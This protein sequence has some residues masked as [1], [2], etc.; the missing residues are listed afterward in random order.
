MEIE[1]RKLNDFCCVECGYIEEYDETHSEYSENECSKLKKKTK[2]LTKFEKKLLKPHVSKLELKINKHQKKVEKKIEQKQSSIYQGIFMIK[3][4]DEFFKKQ[5]LLTTPDL[6]KYAKKVHITYDKKGNEVILD[7]EICKY[8]SWRCELPESHIQHAGCNGCKYI[9]NK[10][11]IFI[12]EDGELQHKLKK[13]K[14]IIDG[15][16]TIDENGNIYFQLNLI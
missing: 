9:S 15:Q 4:L 5:K 6:Y 8:C 1:M 10:Y 7:P 16:T 2:H 14:T 11:D 3:K 12:D 13:S